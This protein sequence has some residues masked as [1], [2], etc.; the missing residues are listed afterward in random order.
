MF[1]VNQI[2][3]PNITHQPSKVLDTLTFHNFSHI[4]AWTTGRTDGWMYKEK[5]ICLLQIGGRHNNKTV[6]QTQQTGCHSHDISLKYRYLQ[7]RE[8]W[9]KESNGLSYSKALNFSVYGKSMGK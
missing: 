1:L 4:H 3:A 2:S 8:K 5:T 9:T 6:P 7:L